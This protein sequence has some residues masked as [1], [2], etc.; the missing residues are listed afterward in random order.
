MPSRWSGGYGSRA[1]ENSVFK[2]NCRILL[3]IEARL[4]SRVHDI[5]H[6]APRI[7]RSCP[8]SYPRSRFPIAS[9]ELGHRLRGAKRTF[10]PAVQGGFR[11]VGVRA[12]DLR[13][14]AGADASTHRDRGGL[15]R[16][17]AVAGPKVGEGE[18]SATPE[19]MKGFPR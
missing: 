4:G 3:Q 17:G 14:G 13:Y 8:K 2:R 5:H 9:V 16:A 6:C 7:A 15:T 19:R 1:C 18:V 11:T 10:A 12:A